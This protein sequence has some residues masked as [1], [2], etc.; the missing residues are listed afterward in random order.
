[1]WLG[2]GRREGRTRFRK[3]MNVK[4]G[5]YGGLC[6]ASAGTVGGPDAQEQVVSSREQ[7]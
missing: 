4:E 5:T 6:K 3:Q 1:M 7:T 2:K